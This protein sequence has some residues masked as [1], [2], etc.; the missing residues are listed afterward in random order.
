[1]SPSAARR[2]IQTIRSGL[3]I[4]QSHPELGHT[5]EGLP[6]NTRDWII[7]FGN[8]AYVV[9]YRIESA[10]VVIAAV[11]HGRELQD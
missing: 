6:A 4:L 5:L 11:R 9:R 8:S 3:R 10:K 1:M 2:A 7:E